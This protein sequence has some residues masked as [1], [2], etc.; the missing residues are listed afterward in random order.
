MEVPRIVTDTTTQR[1]SRRRFMGGAV[2]LAALGSFAAGCGDSDAPPSASVLSPG[3]WA[4]PTA[5][6]SPAGSAAASS[7]ADAELISQRYGLR[8]FAPPPPPP[9][10]KPVTLNASDP[11]VFSHVPLADKVVFV[12]IDDGL[13]KEPGFIQMVKDFQVPITIDLANLFIS[14]NYA[15]FDKLYE[16]GYVSIQNHTVHHPLS[17]PSLSAEQQ[18]DEIAGQ[19][20]I[21]HKQYGVTPYIFR[22]PG[23]NYDATTIAATGQAGLK[24]VMM[25]KETME[26]SDMEYQTS[27]R[28][29]SPGDIILCHFRG[30]AQLDGETM[31]RMMTR[32]FRHIQDQG[33]TVADITKYV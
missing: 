10:V 13:E 29:L 16:T 30:P 24:G 7:G 28:S 18:L 15:Y 25:W 17:M 2:A 20:Q 9:T 4:T 27:V 33:F 3:A 12:T 26:I 5:G 11:T 21:L 31:V 19:Q 8:P 22:P 23:G 6:S 32:L 14:D 1:W